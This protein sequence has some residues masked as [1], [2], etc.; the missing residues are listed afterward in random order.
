[1]NASPL[2]PEMTSVGVWIFPHSA[3]SGRPDMVVPMIRPSYGIVCATASMPAQDG[4]AFNGGS[5]R[6]SRVI[7]GKASVARSARVAPEEMP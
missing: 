6:A 5:Y 1:M 3:G 7:C 2:P 4:S